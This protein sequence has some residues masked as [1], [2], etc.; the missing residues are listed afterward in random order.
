ML[1]DAGCAGFEYIQRRYG[2]Y[3]ESIHDPFTPESRRRI[4]EASQQL[5]A[6]R[7]LLVDELMTVLE[8]SWVGRVKDFSW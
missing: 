1:E 4:A 3:E 5:S 6:Q 2:D 7:N 8:P